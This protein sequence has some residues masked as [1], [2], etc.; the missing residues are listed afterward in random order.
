MAGGLDHIVRAA[1]E[2][3]IAVAIAPREIAG[4]VPAAGEAGA[5]ALLVAEIAAEHGRPAG[6][7]RDFADFVG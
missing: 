2:P 6:P 5:I 1:D 7:Q 3:E 4:E